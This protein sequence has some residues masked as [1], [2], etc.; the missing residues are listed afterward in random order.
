M[1]KILSRSIRQYK[2][3]SILAP[4]FMMLEVM[5]EVLIPFWMASLIDRGITGGDMNYIVKMSV[6]LGLMALLS[7]IFGACSGIFASI[8][9]AGF[10]ANLRSDIFRRVQTFS[11]SNID[12][13]SPASLI[14]RLTTDTNNIMMAYGSIIRMAV[15]AVLMVSFALAMSFQINANIALI[16]VCVIPVLCFGLFFIIL[17]VHP[18]FV[19][20]FG[21]YDALNNIVSENLRGI[22]VVKSFVREKNETE[23]FG[24]VSTDIY[25]DFTKAQKQVAFNMPFLQLCIY[26]CTILISWVGAKLIVSHTMT[27]GELM[28]VI[29]YSMMILMSL[30]LLSIVFVMIVIS[31]TSAQRVVEVLREES[32]LKNPD[33]PI[34]EI[35]DGS[36]SFRDVDFSYV[37]DKKSLCLKGVSL[38]IRSGETIGIIGGTGSSKTTLVQL[39]PRLY[40]ATVGTVLVGGA[41]VRDYDITTLRNAVAVV[42]QNNTLFSG[43]IKENLRW[44][45]ENATDAEIRHACKLAQ[46]DGFIEAFPDGYDTHIEQDGTNVSGGQKQRLCIARALLK[47]PCILI[48]DD[49][50]SAVDTKTD[51]LIRKAF[52]EEIPDTTKLIIAQR[53]S[54]VQ[55]ADRIIVMD[56]GRVN[57]IGTHEELLAGNAIYKEVHDSQVKGG[58]DFDEEK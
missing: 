12:K 16:F 38:Y 2:K 8:A 37:G 36:I 18:I 42:L 32:S 51:A 21:R 27:T 7:L 3:E 22:R 11:F 30:N 45:N 40:D 6:V 25:R 23:K 26:V 15:R 31:R 14:T 44:G 17:H 47:K 50:T 9:S 58:G 56:G 39:I 48:L 43:T 19:R 33:N 5:M 24:G 46:A 49:S 55:D 4:L 34:N 52:R 1:I 13:F 35:K 10:A 54:S 53:I 28:S 20:A 29:S 57:A 41:D